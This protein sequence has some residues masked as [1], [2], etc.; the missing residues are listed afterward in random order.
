[1]PADCTDGFCVAL[2]S[3]PEAHLDPHVRR[4]SSTWHRLSPAVIETGLDR[5]RQDLDSGEWDRRFGHLRTLGTLDI[6]LRLVKAE[7]S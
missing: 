4:A 3:R 5:L 2:W 6:G 7:L 1:V